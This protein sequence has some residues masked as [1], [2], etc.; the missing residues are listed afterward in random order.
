[1]GLAEVALKVSDLQDLELFL[2]SGGP[3][4][5]FVFLF[6]C[7]FTCM[8]VWRVGGL[9]DWQARQIFCVFGV[10]A[11]IIFFL[12]EAWQIGDTGAEHASLYKS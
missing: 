1:M 5:F 7:L 4:S 2:T 12:C 8:P 10:L 6:D 9:A 3:F 11:A